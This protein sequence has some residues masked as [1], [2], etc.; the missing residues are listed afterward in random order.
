[1]YLFHFLISWIQL[2]SKELCSD[3]RIQALGIE[4]GVKSKNE[5]LSLA[6]CN[7]SSVKASHMIIDSILQENKDTFYGEEPC[8]ATIRDGTLPNEME[9]A[10]FRDH[11][12]SL[13]ILYSSAM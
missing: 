11:L 13:E 4:F 2:P 5:C 3:M 8:D 10:S 6:T 9:I 1:M 7:K 12:L